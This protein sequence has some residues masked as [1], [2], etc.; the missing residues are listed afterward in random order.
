METITI[1]DIRDVAN[2]LHRKV[3][4]RHESDLGEE[5]RAFT[6]SGKE[7]DVRKVAAMAISASGAFMQVGHFRRVESGL[8][9][10]DVELAI[11]MMPDVK[12]V[13]RREEATREE[14]EDALYAIVQNHVHASQGNPG[15]TGHLAN[16]ACKVLGLPDVWVPREPS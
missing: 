15:L 14:L 13:P 7:D 2:S 6:L 4:V 11:V 3:R 16:I 8:C 12:G 10:G 5:A 1:Y 9:H